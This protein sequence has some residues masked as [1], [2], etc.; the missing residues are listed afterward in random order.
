[1][2]ITSQETL[3]LVVPLPELVVLL[4]ALLLELLELLLVSLLV[5][6]PFKRILS[7]M[8]SWQPKSFLTTVSPMTQTAAPLRASLSVNCL[9]DF[10]DLFV[11]VK[12]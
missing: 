1:M 8:G 5:L 3:L 10:I 6:L 12:Y 4:L 9:P 2:P 7:P 11:T